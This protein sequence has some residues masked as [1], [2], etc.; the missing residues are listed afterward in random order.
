[1]TREQKLA[2]IVGFA[3]VLVVGV[4]VS[5]HLSGARQLD[6]SGAD[7]VAGGLMPE[8]E[9]PGLGRQFDERAT[10]LTEYEPEPIDATFGQDESR[11]LAD[12]AMAF[13][14][15][16]ADGIMDTLRDAQESPPAAGI[17]R[18][19]EMGRAFPRTVDPEPAPRPRSASSSADRRSMPVHRVAK[20]ES[21]WSIA[22]R[23]YGDGRLHD[24]LAAF[25]EDRIGSD[26]QVRVGAS[27]LIP[28][29]A[30]LTGEAPREVADPAVR[31]GEPRTYVIRAG[32]TLGEISMRLL[33]TSKRM[34]EII[35][36]N[37]KTLADPDRLV[38]GL[39][40]RVPAR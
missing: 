30:A 40:I 37:P 35:D 2:L 17:E 24:E 33:G 36:L 34:R 1:M 31:P 38:A 32:D 18:R 39:E 28:S 12:A 26:G 4:L 10:L 6:S 7:L 22:E 8:V 29:R 27:L 3:L 16:S 5:D 11:T 13:V 23:Y 9:S 21:L 14:S 25:N 20:G 19:I 15:D